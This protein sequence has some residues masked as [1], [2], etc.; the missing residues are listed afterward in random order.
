M[1]QE[2]SRAASEGGE[3]QARL[4]TEI[5]TLR[6]IFA[7]AANGRFLRRGMCFDTSLE[8]KGGHRPRVP[9]CVKIRAGIALRH[10]TGAMQ[11]PAC[12]LPRIRLLRLSEKRNG[13]RSGTPRAA[14]R[15]R[16]RHRSPF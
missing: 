16:T 10:W 14:Q 1:G 11:D 4:D 8:G 12:R 15:S 9:L 5:V 13:P 2:K 7:Y 3:R 6:P